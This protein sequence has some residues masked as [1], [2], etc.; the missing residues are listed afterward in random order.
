M[1]TAHSNTVEM[2]DN[3]LFNCDGLSTELLTAKRN[4][5]SEQSIEMYNFDRG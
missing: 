5:S 3:K 1:L 2:G 4:K